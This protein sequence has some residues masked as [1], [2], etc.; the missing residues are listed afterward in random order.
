MDKITIEGAKLSDIEEIFEL[1][2]SA[3]EFKVSDRV[4]NFWPK[5]VL[6]NCAKSKTDFI[7]AAK[8]AGKL[9]GF[10]IA[11]YNPNF[12]KAVLENI[13]VKPEF[14]THG[15]G[16]KLL[17]SLLHEL[18]ERRC[19][20]VCTLVESGSE[21]SVGYYINNGFNRGIDCVWLDK[22]LSKSFEK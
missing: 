14:R 12:K 3:S 13:Y 4:V 15:V 22:I 9:I 18:K 19:E 10:I 16:K 7:L 20:Y 5:E 6:R 1:G 8:E 2:N 21:N 11:Q 17:E